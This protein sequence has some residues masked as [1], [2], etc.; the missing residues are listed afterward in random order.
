[1]HAVARFCGF[2]FLP[3]SKRFV[4]TSPDP[5]LFQI[6]GP[7]IQKVG[8]F[9]N[10]TPTRVLH[11]FETYQLQCVQLHGDE[12]PGYCRRLSQEGIPVIKALDANTAG[13]RLEEYRDQLS[14]YLFDTPGPGRGGTGQKFDWGLLK[15]IPATFPF[16]LGGGIGPEDAATLLALDHEGLRGV[17]LNSRFELSP[18][19]KDLEKLKEF[20]TKFKTA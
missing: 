6:P 8:V 17:D 7:E 1:M 10:E 4:G 11:S 20:M 19:I 16:L 9:V 5:S 2:Y 13:A 3:G 14:Y 12:S 18:G 15:K